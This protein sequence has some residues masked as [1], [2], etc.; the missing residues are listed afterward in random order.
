[1]SAIRAFIAIELPAR[2]HEAIRNQTARLQQTLGEDL[3]RWIPTHNMHLTLKFL[4]D[5]ALPHID[6]LKQILIREVNSH[7]EFDLQIGGLGSFPNSKRPRI[8]WLGLHA[9]ATLLTIQRD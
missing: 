5:V 4:G 9:P 6:F 2:T 8:L 3:V 7:M 1:M